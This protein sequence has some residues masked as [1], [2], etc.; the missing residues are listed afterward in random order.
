MARVTAVN[1]VFNGG[2]YSPLLSSR[3]DVETRRRGLQRMQNFVPL[4][5]GGARYRKGLRF[6]SEVKDSTKKVR[7]IPFD[8]GIT[9]SPQTYILEFGDLYVRFYKDQAQI[10]SGGS[11][12]E[13]VT[14]YSEDDLDEVQYTQSADVLWL[15]HPAYPTK[16][17]QRTSD[18]SWTITD[19]PYEGGAFRS[20]NTSTTTLAPSATTGSITITAS[21]DTFVSTDVD[22][23]VTIKHGTTWGIAKITGYTSATLVD[24]DVLTDFGATTAQVAWRLGSWSETTGYP[25]TGTLHEQRLILGGTYSEPETIWFSEIGNYNNHLEGTNDADP[26]RYTPG[27]SKVNSVRWIK[28]SMDL[29][30]GTTGSEMNTRKSGNDEAITIGNIKLT[31]QSYYGSNAVDAIPFGESS[32][33]FVQRLGKKVRV[34]NYDIG[35]D[36]YIADDITLLSEH[37]TESGIKEL[38]KFDQPY[39]LVFATK[40]NGEL[41][42]MTFD[43]SQQVAAWSRII[44]DGIIESVATIPGVDFDELWVCVKR[45]INGVE[46]RYVEF[47]DL[48]DDYDLHLDSSYIYDGRRTANLTLGAATGTGVTVTASA[49]VFSANDVGSEIWAD[50][51]SSNI[52]GNSGKATIV[53]YVSDTEITVDID[54]DFSSTSI[55]E[56][57]W[58]VAVDTITGLD[59]LDEK[60]VQVVVNDSKHDDVTVSSNEVG[61]N[62]FASYAFV[63]LGYDGILHTMPIEPAL[64]SGET[65]GKI[66]RISEIIIK[67]LDSKG[68]KL[69]VNAEKLETIAYRG[70]QDSMDSRVELFSGDIKKA[71]P[72]G[73]SREIAPYILQDTPFPMTVLSITSYVEA[74]NG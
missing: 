29:L 15:F 5:Q 50:T 18:T 17:I 21:A 65:I 34:L 27:S 55:L 39:P 8:F 35:F 72:G 36:K 32:I 60:L 16:E 70:L 61:L 48:S 23:L 6:V 4:T 42:A 12:V 28:S 66:K 62:E 40:N 9:S 43:R 13:I 3:V 30:V 26:F 24:A 73:Y 67:L 10:E 52:V 44:T 59:H 1:N 46:K 22:R 38:D 2:E 19:Y 56:D 53:S 63:G 71:V 57:Y 33:A 49:S 25:R 14:P 74:N 37:I 20:E 54:K 31:P 47:W 41:L 69:G 7:L 11:P 45:D 64:P 68:G 51:L 58:A